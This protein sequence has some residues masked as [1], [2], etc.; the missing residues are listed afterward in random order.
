MHLGLRVGTLFKKSKSSGKFK[1]RKFIL[2]HDRIVYSK[3]ISKKG[4]LSSDIPCIHI[5][6]CIYA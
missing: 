2:E 1:K 5:C 4:K 3:D 6:N